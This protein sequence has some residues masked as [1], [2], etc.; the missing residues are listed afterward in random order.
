MKL[1]QLIPATVIAL[2]ASGLFVPLAQAQ[3]TVLDNTSLSSTPGTYLAAYQNGMFG[4][5]IIEMT[6]GFTTGS[7]DSV[8]DSITLDLSA[9]DN[10]GSGLTLSL[11][12]DNGSSMPGSLLETLTGNASPT[13]GGL[14]TYTSSGTALAANTTYWWVASLT[15]PGTGVFATDTTGDSAGTSPEGWT[16]D[17]TYQGDG[18]G[19]WNNIGSTAQFSVDASIGAVPEPSTLALAGMGGLGLAMMFRRPARNAKNPQG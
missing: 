9:D 10:S 19:Y 16:F 1:N 13:A 5:E 18:T 14:V 7:S 8:L 2:S 15:P 17:T 6:S 4:P 11:Y 3:T 12:A